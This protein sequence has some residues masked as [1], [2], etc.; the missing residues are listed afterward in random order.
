MRLKKHFVK[1]DFCHY[2]RVCW[3]IKRVCCLPILAI[4][5]ENRIGHPDTTGA[6]K[7]AR[8]TQP[9]L[10]I[11]K[12]Y[13]RVSPGE[14]Q[15]QGPNTEGSYS[16]T[17]RGPSWQ[18]PCVCQKMVGERTC[19]QRSYMGAW[20]NESINAFAQVQS[21]ILNL[22]TFKLHKSTRSR[23]WHFNTSYL[24]EKNTNQKA[25][26]LSSWHYNDDILWH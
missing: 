4:L 22:E 8:W 17:S 2:A 1:K 15:E 25:Q 19:R 3:K 14:Q 20:V 5:P 24:G 16:E 26:V 9:V 13:Q 18:W 7:Q 11:R 10:H 6:H 23:V 21:Q 12:G